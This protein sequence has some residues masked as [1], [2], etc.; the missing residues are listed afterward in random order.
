MSSLS[1][2]N[3]AAGIDKDRGA[4]YFCVSW[5][6]V[7]EFAVCDLSGYQ[8]LFVVKSHGYQNVVSASHPVDFF[9]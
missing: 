6:R 3:T 7:D 8:I 5:F 9:F 4:G 2:K 1:N